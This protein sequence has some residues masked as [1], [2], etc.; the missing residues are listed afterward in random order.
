MEVIDNRKECEV[1]RAL[2]DPE[3]EAIP[4]HRIRSGQHELLP[5][6]WRHLVMTTRDKYDI[7][8]ITDGMPDNVFRIFVLEPTVICLVPTEVC[9]DHIA[10]RADIA[11]TGF[12]SG[13]DHQPCIIEPAGCVAGKAAKMRFLHGA[14]RHI[15][16]RSFPGFRERGRRRFPGHDTAR[17]RR[18]VINRPHE[19][20]LR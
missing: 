17:L 4:L 5:L 2:N 6:A 19:Q 8:R 14:E 7:G 15:T 9:V 1:V 12:V 10:H 18:P 13:A 20:P 11:P 3:P 16:Y